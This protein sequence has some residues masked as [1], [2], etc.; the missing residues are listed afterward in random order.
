MGR[1]TSPLLLRGASLFVPEAVGPGS[2]LIEG[3]RIAAVYGIGETTPDVESVDLGGAALGP[4]LI[5]VHTHGAAGVESMDGS[6]AVL[7]MARLFV[8]HGVT[9]F[10]PSTV[11][12]SYEAIASGVGGVRRAVAEQCAA[13]ASSHGSRVLGVHLEGP[14]VSPQRLGA[15]SP[16]FCVPPTAENVARLLE[17]AGDVARIV[18]LAPEEDGGLAAIRGFVERG[19]V[20]SV[21]HTVATTAQA[22]AAFAA[23]ARQVTH[24][25]NGMPPLHHRDPGVVGTALTTKGLMIEII[26]DGVHL[27]PTTIRLALAAKGVDE[28]LLVTDSMAATGCEDGEYVLGPLQVFVR[29]GQAR[30]AS[31][32]LAGSTLTLERAVVNVAR[33][34]DA[35]LSGAWQMASLNP[36]RLLGIDDRVGR[37]APGYDADLVAMDASGR[38]VLTMVGGEI[39]HWGMGVI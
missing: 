16:T 33:W 2:V 13:S 36:A 3:G 4:G 30:L 20:V 29:D 9:G 27:A 23:G 25:F 34:T 8:R 18:T 5:D 15:Q 32:N 7:R 1:S 35:G 24:M 38:V 31:G 17:I 11:T 22:E 12:A 14:F 39:A 21:G 6:E 28:V 37:V 26:A 19:I 10:L